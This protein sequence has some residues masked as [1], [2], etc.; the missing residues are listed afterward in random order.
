MDIKE[1]I[2][3]GGVVVRESNRGLEV[4]LISVRRGKRWGLPKGRQEAGET[5]AET[6]LREVEE[7][8]GLKASILAGLGTIV[9]DF[10]FKNGD[11]LSL[12][13]KV[14]HFFLMESTGGDITGFDRHEV[15]DCRWF[16]MK[17]ALAVL[18]YDDEKK[19]LADSEKFLN[20]TRSVG[21]STIKKDK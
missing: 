14:V 21:K 3:A 18:T 17:E 11:T 12:R 9:F 10:N 19:L 20:G 4:A 1:E 5:F 16:P 6:A 7:E 15:D 8:T 13:H 2:S